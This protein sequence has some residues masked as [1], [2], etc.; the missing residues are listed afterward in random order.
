MKCMWEIPVK[1]K[2]IVPCL[3]EQRKN[4]SVLHTCDREITLLKTQAEA[5]RKQKRGLMQKLL[6]GK[7]RMKI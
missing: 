3:E 7:V 5:L 4:A 1:I 6:I 2:V